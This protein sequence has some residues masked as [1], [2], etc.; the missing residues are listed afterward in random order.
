MAMEDLLGKREG[1][2]KQDTSPKSIKLLVQLD[3][4]HQ[5]RDTEYP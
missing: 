1:A 5:K 3:Y 2:E 4:F